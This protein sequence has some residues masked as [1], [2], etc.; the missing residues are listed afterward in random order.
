MATGFGFDRDAVLQ[1]VQQLTGVRSE[2]E[3]ARQQAGQLSAS[4]SRDVDLALRDFTQ[5]AIQHQTTLVA[6][7][8]AVA[9]RLDDV[10][11]GHAELD[12]ALA[13]ERPTH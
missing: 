13:N 1:A 8:A 4:G 6:A 9:G 10:V 5:A 11:T 3:S 2:L 7:V 12:S